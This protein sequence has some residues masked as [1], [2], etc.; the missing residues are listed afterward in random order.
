MLFE[1]FWLFTLFAIGPR[2]PHI[3]ICIEYVIN[4]WPFEMAVQTFLSLFLSQYECW[5]L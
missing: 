2:I 5:N 1:A 4:V 3:N